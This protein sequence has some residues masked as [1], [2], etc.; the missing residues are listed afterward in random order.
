MNSEKIKFTGNTKSFRIIK[1]KAVHELLHK[2]LS[3][4]SNW[5]IKWQMKSIFDKGK[6]YRM[7]KITTCAHCQ[8]LYQLLAFRV[9]MTRA[10]GQFSGKLRAILNIIKTAREISRQT[11]CTNTIYTTSTLCGDDDSKTRKNTE[12]GKGITEIWS[13]SHMRNTI[14][15][16]GK[17]VNTQSV[18]RHT[19][20]RRR[21]EPLCI[22]CFSECR[23]N[24]APK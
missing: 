23:S 8:H 17:A 7:G 24:G 15:Q 3:T 21:T 19:H 20:Q 1:S 5:M 18:S 2:E 14:L 11:H 22:H 13:H 16:A 4:L 6:H 12:K 9:G 10:F